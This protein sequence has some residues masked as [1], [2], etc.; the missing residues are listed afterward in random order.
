MLHIKGTAVLD[1]L[2]AI[3]AG[4]GKQ[5]WIAAVHSTHFDDVQIMSGNEEAEPRNHPLP[6]IFP[7][8][9]DSWDLSL[10]FFPEGAG[11]LRCKESPRALY[12]AQG[13][14]WKIPR[15]GITL[16]LKK[17]GVNSHPFRPEWP[18]CAGSKE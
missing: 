10:W 15:A 12:R 13:S 11:D 14:R 6:G 4:Q 1:T 16:G 2:E 7:D 5:N 3:K 18:A 17:S 8:S 9:P